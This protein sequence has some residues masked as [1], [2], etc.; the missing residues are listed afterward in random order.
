MYVCNKTSSTRGCAFNDS[1]DDK[2]GNI[3]DNKNTFKIIGGRFGNIDLEKWVDRGEGYMG[4]TIIITY[5]KTLK[6]SSEKG[7]TLLE[8]LLST[9]IVGIGFVTSISAS[10]LFRGSLIYR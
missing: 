10:E 7:L 8:A 6:K 4:F 5:L 1:S 2:E 3:D 9:A